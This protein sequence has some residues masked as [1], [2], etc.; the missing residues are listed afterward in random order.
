[1]ACKAQNIYYLA[2]YRKSVLTA[3]LKDPKRSK[4]TQ[5]GTDSRQATKETGGPSKMYLDST[6]HLGPLSP[7]GIMALG[8]LRWF[9]PSGHRGSIQKGEVT[10]VTVLTVKSPSLPCCLR[11]TTNG[12]RRGKRCCWESRSCAQASACQ[13]RPLT[14]AKSTALQCF[15]F[16]PKTHL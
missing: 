11:R 6:P 10:W 1:M 7:Q 2:L 5:R 15:P 12:G 9:R 8:Q 4:T 16:K 13:V 14:N 3:A